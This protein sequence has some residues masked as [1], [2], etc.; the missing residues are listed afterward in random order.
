M[1]PWKGLLRVLDS[2]GPQQNLPR[3]LLKLTL[4]RCPVRLLNLHP[5]LLP[6]HSPQPGGGVCDCVEEAGFT[7]EAVAPG[8]HS[9]FAPMTDQ[10][11]HDNEK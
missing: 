3:I 1:L 10:I 11:S 5:V 7:M 9:Q 2:F 6:L 8:E 4:E